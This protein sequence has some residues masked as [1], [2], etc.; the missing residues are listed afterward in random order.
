MNTATLATIVIISACVIVLWGCAAIALN[1]LYTE[2][3]R[4]QGIAGIIA[5]AIGFVVLGIAIWLAALS[6][7]TN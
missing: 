7:I 1:D 2:P 4:W 3:K 5:C 6:A